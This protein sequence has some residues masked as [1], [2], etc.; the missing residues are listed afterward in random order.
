MSDCLFCKIAA[1][2]IPSTKVYEDETV[3]AF[4]DIAPQAA[5]HILVIPKNH[6]GSVAEIDRDNSAVVAHIFEVIPAIAKAEGLTNGYRV[7]SNC[8]ADAGQ[9]VHHLHFHILGGK[10]LSLEENHRFDNDPVIAGGTFYCRKPLSSFMGAY[11]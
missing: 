5:T 9:T 8:G 1:G 11:S 4:R 10:K 6:I 3:L 7:V 2:Q